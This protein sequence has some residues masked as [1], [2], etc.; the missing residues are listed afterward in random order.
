MKFS[1]ALLVVVLSMS[2]VST[3]C[4]AKWVTVAQADLPLIVNL[5]TAVLQ[6]ANPGDQKNV[7]EYAAEAQTDLR[8]VQTLI[9]EYNKA[10][11]TAKLTTQQKII[12]T[13]T[14]ASNHLNAILQAA[15]VSNSVESQ[16]IAAAVQLAILTVNTITALMANSKTASASALPTPEDLQ[17]VVADL[18]SFKT[19]AS[20]T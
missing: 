14:E 5:V 11:G 16:H 4:S 19:K 1:K 8:L 17:K 13:L 10:S 20:I 6:L 18:Q 9:D 7:V 3:G 12:Q 2:L 15:H